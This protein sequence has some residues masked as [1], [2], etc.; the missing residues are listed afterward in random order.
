MFKAKQIVGRGQI[1][2]ILPYIT[3]DEDC[4]EDSKERKDSRDGKDTKELIGMEE[5]ELELE[6]L[7]ISDDII[8]EEEV[9][10]ET[11]DFSQ[12]FLEEHEQDEMEASTGSHLKL[13]VD[14][15]LQQFPNCVN[16]DLIGK[17]DAA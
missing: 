8:G 10:G 7:D 11:E 5:L 17:V 4:T 3:L 2:K 14:V 16:R 13:I 6:N 9:T 15:F 12:K 1:R